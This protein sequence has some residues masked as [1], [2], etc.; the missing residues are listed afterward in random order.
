MT[1]VQ[2]IVAAVG[3]HHFPARPL[4][5]GPRGD[6]LFTIVEFVRHFRGSLRSFQEPADIRKLRAQLIVQR[7]V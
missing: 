4:P 2:Q 1:G 5:S 7:I 6:Q 3:E